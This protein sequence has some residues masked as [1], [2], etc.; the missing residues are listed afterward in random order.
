MTTTIKIA[1]V[2]ASLI[3]ACHFDPV[4]ESLATESSSSTDGGTFVT[5]TQTTGATAITTTSA[6]TTTDG[7]E[8]GDAT[9]T[10]TFGDDATTTYSESSTGGTSS[11]ASSSETSVAGICEFNGEACMDD[12]DCGIPGIC[13]ADTQHCFHWCASDE[14]CPAGTTCF[15]PGA[16]GSYCA[17]CAGD[18]SLCAGGAECNGNDCAEPN[19]PE[20]DTSGMPCVI[21]DHC[22]LS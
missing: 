5:T 22:V 18:D 12:T 3:C 17:A 14:D 8:S 2:L 11:S 6:T 4:G 7:S 16:F 20:C 10:E 9:S 1:L 15:I 19:H 13:Y 21:S